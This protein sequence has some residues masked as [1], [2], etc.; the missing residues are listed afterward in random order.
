MILKWFNYRVREMNSIYLA[1]IKVQPLTL[2]NTVMSLLA[3]YN[4]DISRFT[5]RLLASQENPHPMQ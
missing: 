3:S 2:V 5:E 4:M 1:Q